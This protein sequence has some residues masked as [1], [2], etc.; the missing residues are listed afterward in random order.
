MNPITQTLVSIVTP[1]LN[2]ARFIE[3]TV[4]SVL[5]QDYANLEYIVIDGGSTDGTLE[6][7]ERYKG[8]LRL[9]SEPDSGTSD[10]LAKG[11][12]LAS[13]QIFGY[14]NA[15]D[16]YLP[17]AI[18]AA[19]DQLSGSPGAAAVYGNA[20]WITGEGLR[21][22]R[23]PVSSWEPELLSQ[24]CFICQPACFFRAAAYREAGGIDPKL[25]SAFDYD[26]WLRLSKNRTFVFLER[27]LANSRMHHENK[28]LSERR[29]VFLESLAAVR[30]HCGYVPFQWIHG[31]SSY[32]I[33][34]RDQFFEPLRPSFTKYVL[35]L[36]VGTLYNVRHPLRYWREWGSVMS[37]GAFLRRW[38]ASW[39]AR[40]LGLQIR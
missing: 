19:V 14:L 24:S 32:V 20:Y 5:E 3:E 8:R 37:L 16:T 12:S 39:L 11:F 28:S 10:A 35:S 30:Q 7:L 27:S 21:L 4:Q 26:L 1:C 36:F 13:G 15:D 2:M 9:V 29:S 40:T 18:R 38:N 33:D 22:G 25:H 34:G 6:I 17:G 31:F 23:Y